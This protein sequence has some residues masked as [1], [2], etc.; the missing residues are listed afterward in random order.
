[1]TVRR[2]LPGIA[3][4]LGLSAITIGSAVAYSDLWA[5][6]YICTGGSTATTCVINAAV[7]QNSAVIYKAFTVTLRQT[8]SGTVT[9]FGYGTGGSS[10]STST[11]STSNAISS[12]TV[13]VATAS[14]P[15][16]PSFY[17]GAVRADR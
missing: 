3:L 10:V 5:Y 9:G 8:I 15:E 6:N 11:S 17:R 2:W 7:S 13:S 1:M 16:T 4:G 14:S 12:S